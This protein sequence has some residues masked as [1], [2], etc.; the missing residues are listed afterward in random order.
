MTSER[1]AAVQRNVELEAEIVA[2]KSRVAEAENRPPEKVI[3]KDTSETNAFRAKVDALSAACGA[4]PEMETVAMQVFI[5][6]RERAAE[7]L[8]ACGIDWKSWVLMSRTYATRQSME[9][10]VDA[11]VRETADSLRLVG[12]RALFDSEPGF[13]L[14]SVPLP[15][16]DTRQ[17]ID[18]VL[19]CDRSG[20]SFST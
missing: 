6:L 18:L 10:V 3:V 16:L 2:L 13:E 17:K 19:L 9:H 4:I 7:F 15:D 8:T 11:C 20:Q 5:R 14:I 1:D 12:F